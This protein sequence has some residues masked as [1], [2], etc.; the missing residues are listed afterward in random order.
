MKKIYLILLAL[1]PL[2]IFAQIPNPQPVITASGVTSCSGG[3]TLRV[4]SVGPNSYYYWMYNGQQI[5][6]SQGIYY[7]TDTFYVARYSGTYTVFD[8]TASFPSVYST[9]FSDTS[10]P[11]VVTGLP[12][13]GI[14][15]GQRGSSGV[16]YG[17][18]AQLY[19][20]HFGSA[21]YQWYKNSAAITGAIDTLIYASSS[22][23]YS[24]QISFAGGCAQTIDTTITVASSLTATLSKNAFGD[25][26]VVSANG[27][28][29]PY[30]YQTPWIYSTIH[31][32]QNEFPVDSAGSCAAVVYDA[33][34]CTVTT[35]TVVLT[36]DTIKG[37]VLNSSNA[38][39]AN[40]TVQLVVE[41]S[42]APAL[43]FYTTT[44]A[45]GNYVIPTAL[46]QGYLLAIP[47][48]GLGYLPTYYA[49]SPVI[50]SA[51]LVQFTSTNI[52]P[53]TIVLI[54][55]AQ[56]SGNGQISGVINSSSSSSNRLTT[57]STNS[58]P[59]AGL[60]IV[61]LNANNQPVASTTTN[62]SGFFEFT[63]LAP[64]NYKLWVDGNG[65]DNTT[66]PV[67]TVSS[68]SS[69]SSTNLQLAISGNN[70]TISS[71][72]GITSASNTS[73]GI[74][75]YPNPVSSVLN[76]SVYGS[77]FTNFS[78][79]LTNGQGHQLLKGQGN[80]T[81]DISG[82]EPGLYILSVQTAETVGYQKVIIER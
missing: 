82:M 48:A 4:S 52:Y 55:A 72:T 19:V 42:G 51:A 49:S 34:G 78:Y 65:I 22:G 35:N 58:G 33:N 21:T 38:P 15:I 16:C 25:S 50:Q 81:I 39:V 32:Q 80:S 44:D 18:S 7:T 24:V 77:Q 67:V 46:T 43:V 1:L 31:Y 61:L 68:G 75:I 36:E 60:T 56:S 9:I 57:A 71:V 14:T 73:A 74:S 11:Y 64:G 54:D 23:A 79:T 13:S 76:V 8:S 70:L 69:I 41:R 12:L 28:T 2:S 29:P 17:D 10:V 3:D 59:I 53:D 62:A 63:D 5:E 47:A 27:G 26:L 40:V 37:I 6:V 30:T 66:A 20:P 45:N